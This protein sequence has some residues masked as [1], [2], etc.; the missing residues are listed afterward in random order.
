MPKTFGQFSAM[1]DFC[2]CLYIYT[3]L[4]AIANR[5]IVPIYFYL[6]RIKGNGYE[7]RRITDKNPET[8]P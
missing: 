6:C 7:K 3:K 2:C 4:K 1:C 5:Y 8:E